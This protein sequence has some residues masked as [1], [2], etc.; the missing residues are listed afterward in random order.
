MPEVRSPFGGEQGLQSSAELTI[1]RLSVT[2]IGA[3]TA[4]RRDGARS[5]VSGGTMRFL[6]S[7]LTILVFA[8]WVGV[9][10]LL[11]GVSL[12]AWWRQQEMRAR[13]A[14]S[15]PSAVIASPGAPDGA[16]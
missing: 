7:I 13:D 5:I 9:A 16:V 10:A 12:D 2:R 4:N 1:I 11:A 3:P 8:S 14:T 6:E 15:E